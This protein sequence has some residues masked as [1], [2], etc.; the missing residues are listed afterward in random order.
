[1]TML[2]R[3][4]SGLQIALLL[5]AA[6]DLF[7]ASY[8]PM[9]DEDLVDRT[10]L[11]AVAW[12]DGASAA[13]TQRPA[14]DYFLEVEEVLKGSL[15]GRHLV[16]RVPGGVRPDGLGLKI[17]GA[18]A[19]RP[20][21]RVLVFLVP[22]SE[23]TWVLSQLMLGA[24]FEVPAVGGSLALRDLSKAQAVPRR[25]RNLDPELAVRDFDAFRTW[26]AARSLGRRQAADYWRVDPQP[27]AGLAARPEAFTLFEDGGTGFNFR[28]PDFDLGNPVTFFAHQDGQPGLPGGGFLE[29]QEALAAWSAVD[30]T[31]IDFR[32][33]GTTTAS[34]GLSFPCDLP[35]PP[36]CTIDSLVNAIVFDDPN[37]NF[38]LFGGPFSCTAGGVLAAGGPW[39]DSFLTHTYH[40]H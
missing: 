4:A 37:D 13:P 40:G 10:P 33:G 21:E 31:L 22:G 5:A 24:F 30:C 6:S 25:G 38:D 18:P 36:V 26:I 29:F 8:V 27:I 11:I 32:Y 3:G 1:M 19:F 14:T 9:R 23:G 15:A 35:E 39:F 7:A 28:W 20:E 16:L 34:G 2:K 12:V 17:W